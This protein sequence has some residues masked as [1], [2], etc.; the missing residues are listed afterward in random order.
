MSSNI[1][2]LVFLLFLAI[3]FELFAEIDGL[4]DIIRQAALDTGYL[5]PE[6]THIDGDIELAASGDKLFRSEHLSLNA[7][8]SCS[9]CHISEKAS[10]DGLPNAAG[11]YGI[12]ES[13]ERFMSG[14]KIV[15]RNTLALWGVGG[16]FFERFFWD[17]RV[18]FSSEQII[19]QFGTEVPS[20]DPL[21]TAVHLPVVE[22]RE[23]IDEDDFIREQKRESVGGARTV[24]EA[25][26]RNLKREEPDLMESL[27]TTVDKSVEE[28][29]FLDVAKAIASFMRN[30][31]KLTNSK[32]SRFMEGDVTLSK[33]E[34]KGAS[35]FYGKGGCASCHSGPYFSDFDF[36][37][38]P[39][40]QLGFGKNGFGI[41]YGR[42][43][44]TFDPADLYK[45][46]TPSLVNVAVTKPYG[47][48]GSIPD[49][50]QAIMSH[51]DPLKVTD[52]G[53]LNP[54]Q[55]HEFY[56][57]LATSDTFTI[58]NFLTDDEVTLL[59][60]FLNTFTMEALK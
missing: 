28:L 59:V 42:Y 48:S 23:T 14:A 11:I 55:R 43:N 6:H 36:H 58:V 50:K 57:Y 16:K 34:L 15:P 37:T 12:G 7:S 17:G 18:D 32:F 20:S 45:F 29:E 10:V 54:L 5:S 26:T 46:R 33:K 30:E 56:K 38:V 52:T 41:D 39:F 3:S 40:P 4:S 19:S 31:F 53:S 51:F 13:R 27:A 47:H 24:Y 22:I 8:I 9:T 44:V 21:V 2:S 35:V 1:K 49:L 25:I 60:S